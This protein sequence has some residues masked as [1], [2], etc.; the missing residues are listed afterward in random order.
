MLATVLIVVLQCCYA[1]SFGGFHPYVQE[2]AAR[3]AG[4][5]LAMTNSCR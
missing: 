1:A 3:D 4:V 2:V 5:I